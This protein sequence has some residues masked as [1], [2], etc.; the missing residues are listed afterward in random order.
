MYLGYSVGYTLNTG[1][2]TDT[3]E[4][5]PFKSAMMLG[6]TKLNNSIPVWMTLTFTQGHTVT[7]KQEFTQL[8]CYK[9]A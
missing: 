3:Y 6:T 4:P 8:Q 5:I 2:C 7:R 9:V 1:L